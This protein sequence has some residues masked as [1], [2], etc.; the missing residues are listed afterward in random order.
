[1]EDIDGGLHPAVDGQSLDEDEDKSFMTVTSLFSFCSYISGGYHTGESFACVTSSNHTVVTL[2]LQVW[3]MLSV[4]LLQAFTHLGNKHQVLYSPCDGMNANKTRQDINL[5]SL[6]KELRVATPAAMQRSNH[7]HARRV[8]WTSSLQTKSV[9][10][11]IR[12]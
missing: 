10:L 5:H 11:N 6:L 1:M 7:W 4:F 9:L 12:K 3:C 8:D 2:Q